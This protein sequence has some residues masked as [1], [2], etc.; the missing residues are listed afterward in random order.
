MSRKFTGSDY[1]EFGPGTLS[2]F[3][4]GPSTVVA[5]WRASSIHKGTIIDSRTV[6][7]SVVCSFRCA[8][9]GMEWYAYNGVNNFDQCQPYTAST[10]RI[11]A[12]TKNSGNSTIR[13]HYCPISGSWTH[14]NYGTKTTSA[15]PHSK[16]IVGNGN[17]LGGLQGDVAAIMLLDRILSDAEIETLWSGLTAW[18]SLIGSDSALLWAFNQ[19]SVSDPVLDLTGGGG[20]QI[21]ISGT[22]IETDPP[23]FSYLLL[24]PTDCQLNANLPSLDF[25]VTEISLVT[26][27]FATNL[28]KLAVHLTLGVS[29]SPPMMVATATTRELLGTA[30]VV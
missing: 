19:A 6:S 23:G 13:G 26:G 28:P 20:D 29:I 17:S 2:D 18:M 4:G 24:T 10:W 5:L 7:D 14:V 9:T 27:T 22:S 11:D 8:V 25:A 16:I 3:V 15:S 30:T 12:W 21:A 1:V